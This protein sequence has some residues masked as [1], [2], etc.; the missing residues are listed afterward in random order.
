MSAVPDRRFRPQPLDWLVV[1]LPAALAVLL[2]VWKLPERSLWLDEGA[3]LSIAS[4]HGARLW[5]AI[6][7]DGGNMLIYYLGLH[8][9]ISL[10]GDGLVVLR[11]ISVLADGLT[12]GLVSLLG[13]RLF[14]SRAVAGV[15]GAL[16]ALSVGLVF[17]GQDARGYAA[18]VTAGTASFY[19]LVV[20]VQSDSRDA[21]ARGALIGYVLATTLAL[22]IGFDA[23]LLLPAQLLLVLL[24]RR[25]VR[26]LIGAVGVIAALCAPLVVLAVDRGSDQ[27]FWV[28]TLSPEVLWQTLVTLVSAGLPPNFRVGVLTVA[29]VVV[30]S[31]VGLIALVLAW[32]ARQDRE[33]GLVLVPVLWLVVPALVGVVAAAIGEPIE[34]A[35]ISILLM[36][37]LALLLAWVL[38]GPRDGLAAVPGRLGS[39]G[40][41]FAVGMLGL[42]VILALRLAVLIPSYSATPEPWKEVAARVLRAGR[43]G[44]CV[45]FYPQDGRMPFGYYVQ[46]TPGAVSRAPRPLL[47]REP[48]SARTPHVEQYDVPSAA[49]LSALT[50]GC[51]RVWL[52][53][54]HQGQAHGREISQRHFDGYEA[55]RREL[56]AMFGSPL[57]SRSGYAAAINVFLY[58]R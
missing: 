14:A 57:S 32:R 6:A 13:L 47:P 36:P 23:V 27:L 24:L 42:A 26:A 7:H 38:I 46:R 11:G 18:M 49:A 54:S 19:A 44:D 25:R 40:V 16:T 31:A 51:G 3:S 41:S 53:S 28:P 30:F 35:R 20:L 9:L 12:A 55:F 56:S 15:A 50:R 21:P 10:F 29:G 48:W 5:S 33:A 4:Q 34:L 58:T 1:A 22:Y 17:W 43:A 2:C 37:A 8:L 39:P 45:A 52:I